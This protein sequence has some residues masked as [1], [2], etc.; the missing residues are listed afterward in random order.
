MRAGIIM[1]HCLLIIA[2][3]LY[4]LLNIST[5]MHTI[6]MM[7]AIIYITTNARMYVYWQCKAMK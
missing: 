6:D 5:L 1:L 3:I 2:G 7:Y 4:I